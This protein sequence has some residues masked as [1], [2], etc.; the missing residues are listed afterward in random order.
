MAPA[1][2]TSNPDGSTSIQIRG[3]VDAPRRARRWVLSQ[4]GSHI[5]PT[6]ASDI[7]VIVSELVTNSVLH[8]DVG[9]SQT[10][11]LELITLDDRLRISVIDPGSPFEPRILPPDHQRVGGFGLFLVSELSEAWGVALDGTGGTR[12]WSDTHAW[13]QSIPSGRID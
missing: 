2:E 9:L 4:L 1:L 12:V 5:A 3:G 8:A 10:L 11:T 13:E 7:A 6:T